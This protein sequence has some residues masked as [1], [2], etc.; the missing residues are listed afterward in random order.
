MRLISAATYS[1][2]DLQRAQRTDLVTLALL[3]LV[4][5]PDLEK[6][7]GRPWESKEMKEL[8]VQVDADVRKIVT[9][10]YNQWKDQLYLNSQGILCCRRKPSEKIYDHNAIVLPQFYHAE[11]LYRAHDDQGHQGVDK[12]FARIRQRFIWPG[13]NN[14]VRRWFKVWR[15]C[16]ASK[17]PPGGKKLP[18][19]NIVSGS[20]TEIVQI[21]HQKICQ[22]KSGYT[23]ILVMIDHFTKYDE[24]APCREYTAEETCQHLMNYWIA[25][26]GVP[27]FVQSDNGIQFAA[28]MTQEFLASAKAVQVFSN[29]Y[30]PRCNGLVERQNRTLAHMLRVSCT[31]HMDDWDKFLPQVVG[32]YNSTRHATTG[33]SP[34]M[35]LTGRERHLPLV[36]FYPEFEKTADS[37]SQYVRKTIERRQ[38][39]NELLRANTQQAQLRQN[40]NFDKGCR[41]PKAY[42]VGDWVRV[43]CKI[44]PA[45]GTAKLLRGWRGPFRVTE[46]RQEGRYYHL[47]NGNKAHYEIPKP[48]FSGIDEFEVAD[49][50]DDDEI[51]PNPMKLKSM[52]DGNLT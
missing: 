8:E 50:S 45:G 29:T 31:R 7:Q 1:L 25:R 5:I 46:V 37:P 15:L 42:K 44:I 12:V 26:H 21:D 36:Y 43:F 22:N 40:R 24:V 14:A 27:T 49:Q 17:T 48:H 38:E 30:K 4:Q 23:G 19:K 11:M 2:N 10:F 51:V 9:E 32:A 20:F 39:L 47:S 34:H 35:L 13:V 16:Q 6:I 18:L 41:G 28:H 3:K 33:V 52:W